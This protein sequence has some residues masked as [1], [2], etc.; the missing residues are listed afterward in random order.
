LAHTLHGKHGTLTSCCKQNVSVTTRANGS[1]HH[2]SS[3]FGCC[4]FRRDDAGEW[5]VCKAY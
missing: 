3:P 2:R 1:H 5:V 4:K